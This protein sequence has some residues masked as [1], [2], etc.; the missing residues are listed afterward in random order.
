MITGIV[1]S[2]LIGII[3]ALVAGGI[4]LGSSSSV[5]ISI[6]LFIE[7]ASNGNTP[8]NVASANKQ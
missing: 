2:G 8:A 5:I 7:H 4:N 1:A 3:T 6:L